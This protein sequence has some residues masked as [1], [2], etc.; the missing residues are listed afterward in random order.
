MGTDNQQCFNRSACFHE[1][2][3]QMNCDNGDTLFVDND[4][5]STIQHSFWVITND[6]DQ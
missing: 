1:E 5:F 2:Y 6:L 4:L 3:L